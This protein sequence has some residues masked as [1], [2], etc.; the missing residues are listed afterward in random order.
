[1]NV[2]TFVAAD[3]GLIMLNRTKEMDLFHLST[4]NSHTLMPNEVLDFI[5]LN[6]IVI[7][8][9]DPND[10]SQDPKYNVVRLKP[11]LMEKQGL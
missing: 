7:S 5:T 4:S 8:N 9:Y 3:S 6:Q 11:I 10:K 1:V 2:G